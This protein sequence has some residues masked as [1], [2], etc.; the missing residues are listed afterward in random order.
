MRAT[1]GDRVAAGWVAAAAAMSCTVSAYR[2]KAVSRAACTPALRRVSA[3]VVAS[4]SAVAIPAVAAAPVPSPR[5]SVAAAR[6][7]PRGPAAR[8]H[9]VNVTLPLSEPPERD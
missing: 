1:V 3:A 6:A 9:L 2:W 4:R 5:A 8:I 7:V